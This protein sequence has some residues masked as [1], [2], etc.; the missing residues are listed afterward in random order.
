MDLARILK[1]NGLLVLTF[2]SRNV[3]EHTDDSGTLNQGEFVFRTTKKL[4]GILPDW[5]QT[6]F[7]SQDLTTKL[8]NE[9]FQDVAY[10]PNAFGNQ[11]AALARRPNAVSLIPQQA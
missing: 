1:P 5:Y 11:D 9:F 7:Q 8:L 2:H 10:V 6:A 3:W 4:K